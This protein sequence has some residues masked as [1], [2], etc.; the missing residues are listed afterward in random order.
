[1]FVPAKDHAQYQ[2]YEGFLSQNVLTACDFD[3]WFLYILAGWE[4]S[5]HDERVL[6]DAQTARGFH[7]PKEKYWLGR[8]RIWLFRVYFGTI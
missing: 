7:T 2:N 8:C 6:Q 4:G 5:A 3:M 1:M